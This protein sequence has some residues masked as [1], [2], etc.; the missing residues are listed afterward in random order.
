MHSDF[1]QTMPHRGAV[2]YQS[3]VKELFKRSEGQGSL[4]SITVDGES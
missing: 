3:N 1:S 4:E 2:F